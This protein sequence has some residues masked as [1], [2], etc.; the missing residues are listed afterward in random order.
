MLS[1]TMHI[2]TVL[3]V[4]FKCVTEFHNTT[5]S[6]NLVIIN[7]KNIILKDKKTTHPVP[8]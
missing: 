2:K 4:G 1:Q 7:K 3:S 5:E 6:F 8:C